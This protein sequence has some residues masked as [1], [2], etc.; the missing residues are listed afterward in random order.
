MSF[1]ET[2]LQEASTQEAESVL[3]EAK[4]K[5]K[6]CDESDDEEDD[7][8]DRPVPQSSKRKKQLD[9]CESGPIVLI[10]N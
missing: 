4:P 7:R 1:A 3:E 10:I 9:T 8:S 6:K 2:H 5:K